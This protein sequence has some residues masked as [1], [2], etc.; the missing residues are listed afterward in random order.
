MNSLIIDVVDTGGQAVARADSRMNKTRSAEQDALCVAGKEI[1][2][3]MKAQHNT[4]A[5]LTLNFLVFLR[6]LVLPPQQRRVLDGYRNVLGSV[7]FAKPSLPHAL[8]QN[9][10]VLDVR[11]HFDCLLRHL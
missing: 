5:D 6:T 2:A 3:Y 11:V 8:G 1:R 7:L 10:R 9:E 4:I